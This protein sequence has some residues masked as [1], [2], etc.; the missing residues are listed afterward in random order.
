[1][2]VI[3]VSLDCVRPD[4]LSCYGYKKETTPFID[5]LAKQGA[6]FVNAYANG[7]FTP[8]R[9]SPRILLLNAAMLRLRSKSLCG[10]AQRKSEIYRY[11]LLYCLTNTYLKQ[12]SKHYF[13]KMNL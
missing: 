10:L 7:P 8:G 13:I 9:R 3:I 11:V 5:S 1:M 4:Y 2:N 6:K 12:K